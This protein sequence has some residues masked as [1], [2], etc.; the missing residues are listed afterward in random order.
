MILQKTHEGATHPFARKGN[1][2]PERDNKL[3]CEQV[4]IAHHPWPWFIQGTPWERHK[5]G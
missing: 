2:G 5:K 1:L 4:H 3:P